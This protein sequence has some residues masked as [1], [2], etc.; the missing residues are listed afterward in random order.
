[1]KIFWHMKLS[2]NH[3]QIVQQRQMSSDTKYFVRLRIGHKSEMLDRPTS[4]GMT[5]RWTVFVHSFSGMPFTDRSFISKVVF[6]LHPDFS[7]PRRVVKE[8][9]FEVSELGYGGFSIPIHITF[10]GASKVYKLT[11]DMNLVLEKY[12]EQFITQTI[13]MKQPSSSFRELILK[14]GGAKKDSDKRKEK[15]R[16]RKGTISSSEEPAPKR[17]KE[18][19]KGRSGSNPPLSKLKIPRALVDGEKKRKNTRSSSSENI[20]NIPK[21]VIP[22][23]ETKSSSNTETKAA[24]PPGIKQTETISSEPSTSAESNCSDSETSK[25]TTFGTEST[26]SLTPTLE[27]DCMIEKQY[28]FEFLVRLQKKLM[29][30]KDPDKMLAVVNTLLTPTSS[31]PSLPSGLLFTDNNLLSFDICKLN[32]SLIGKLGEICFGNTPK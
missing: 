22:A 3:L 26:V 27:S 6:E 9:P 2:T 4:T 19:E 30:L 8:P 25:V 5:H 10:T 7:S 23:A 28:S 11:Y 16:L 29:T 24:V 21:S 15:H 17:E 20:A 32:S 14:Y 1:M 12:N 31:N 13:E 18:K